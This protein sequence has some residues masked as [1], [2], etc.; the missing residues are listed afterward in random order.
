MEKDLNE[1]L[2]RG[3]KEMKEQPEKAQRVICW[4]V[5]NFDFV[6]EMCKESDMTDEEIEKYKESARKKEEYITIVLLCIAEMHKN[7]GY[8]TMGQIELIIKGVE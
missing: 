7:R 8:E 5:E 4:L 3:E 6:I 1:E 2:V